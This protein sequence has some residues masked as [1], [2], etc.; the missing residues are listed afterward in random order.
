MS[1]EANKKIHVKFLH[2]MLNV[3]PTPYS[4]QESNRITLA[5][6]VVS[7]L[8][9]LGELDNLDKKRIIDF[10]YSLQ[11]LPDKDDQSKN[12]QNCGFRGGPFFGSPW[13]PTCEAKSLHIHD[14]S[15]MAMTYTALAI[16]TMCGDNF[17]RVNKVA[18]INAIKSLQKEDGSFSPVAGGSESDVRFIYTA[19]AISYMLNDFSGVNID[20]AVNYIISSQS[21][22]GA[23]GQGPGQE[24]HGGATYCAVASLHLFGKLDKLPRKEALIKWCIE[25]QI[26]GFQGR[27]NKDP[28]SCYSF[29]IG[30]S[31]TLLG[32][33]SLLD[34]NSIKGF[35]FSCEQKKGG[36]SKNQINI[37]MYFTH[38]CH[39]VVFLWEVNL[40]L[41]RL[42]VDWVLVREP[43]NG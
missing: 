37:L 29:W 7:S 32:G 14:Q 31:L 22:D 6:F 13:N 36:F 42:I 1:L 18:V 5:Y 10:I 34:F 35:T 39:C 11:V 40:E 9:I 41:H 19:A 28:D 26:S 3:L 16:L 23:I 2:Y 30:A 15:N 27:I 8:D 33:Y 25:R 43:L 17:S 24:S 20:K 4:S 38:T 12:I 21:Y